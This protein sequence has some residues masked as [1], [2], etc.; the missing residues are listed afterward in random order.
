MPSKKKGNATKRRPRQKTIKEHIPDEKFVTKFLAVMQRFPAC[1]L[2][3]MSL[4]DEFV[5]DTFFYRLVQFTNVERIEFKPRLLLMAFMIV[6]FPDL[7]VSCKCNPFRQSLIYR[8][9]GFVDATFQVTMDCSQSED[10]SLQD[11]LPV[12]IVDNFVA[13]L[14]Q[15]LQA[16]KLYRRFLIGIPCK[17]QGTM[18]HF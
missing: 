15:Y 11:F 14:N 6:N 16:L 12:D 8:S 10:D 4:D 18:L 2:G 1:K 7:F 13:R 3:E 5:V 17:C 9:L